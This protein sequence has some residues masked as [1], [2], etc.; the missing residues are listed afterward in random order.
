MTAESDTGKQSAAA[1][2]PPRKSWVL[3][4]LP[5]AA[6]AALAAIFL[7]QLMSGRDAAEI[8]SALIGQP[9]P[10]TRLAALDGSGLPGVDSALFKGKVTVLNVWSSWCA[11]CREEHPILL[12]LAQDGRFDLAGLDYKDPPD[13]ALKF[14]T[15]FGTPFSAIG[16]DPD[17][18]TAINWGVYGVPETFV[19][20]KDGRIAFKHVGPL[21]VDSAKA[22]LLPQIEKALAAR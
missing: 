9:A 15:E 13:K 4:L 3:A 19:V 8:P 5:L 7:V 17:G 12:G 21:T 22:E 11:P 10:A 16:V 14:L 20:G 1:V 6:F 2:G 18:R